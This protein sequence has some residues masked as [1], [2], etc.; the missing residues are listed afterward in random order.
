MHPTIFEFTDVAD[1]KKAYEA[2]II[3]ETSHINPL[4]GQIEGKGGLHSVRSLCGRGRLIAFR[5]PGFCWIP[6]H[7]EALRD[8]GLTIDFSAKI[9]TIPVCY[10]GI[11][12]CPYPVLLEW[13]GQQVD[14]RTL[15]NSMLKRDLVVIGL[16]PSL[17]VNQDNWDSIYQRGNPTNLST[18]KPR[19]GSECRSVF[20]SFE[21][22]LKRLKRLEKIGLIEV[23]ADLKKPQEV[24]VPEKAHVEEICDFS[25]RWP[26]RVFRYEPKYLRKHFYDFFEIQE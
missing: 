18:P 1:Y 19:T 8:N 25:L 21:L 10:K 7:S 26:R 2:S 24:L 14:Y 22:L 12:F 4:N 5:A 6:P 13:N 3:R 17:F 23:S 15:L 16:H 9:A 20:K 11:I